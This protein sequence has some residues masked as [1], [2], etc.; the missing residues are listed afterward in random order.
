MSRFAK[1][2]RILGSLCILLNLAAVF[3]PFARRVQEN[4]ADFTWSQWDYIQGML[5]NFLPFVE[6]GELTL[7]AGSAVWVL[8]LLLLPLLLSVA[9]GVWGMAGSYTQKGSSILIFAVLLFYAGMAV[10]SPSVWPEA[11][12]G[13]NIVRGLAGILP[14]GFSGAAAVW[15]VLSLMATPGKVEISEAAIPQVEEI[16]QEQVE[17]KYSIMMEEQKQQP[18]EP[19]HGVLIGLSGMYAGARIPMTDGE[20]LLLGRQADNHLVFE[21]QEN[22]SRSHC[23]IKWD[24]A[25]GKY[26]IRDYSSTG[27]YLNGTEDCLP[28]N[29]DLA[30]APGSRIALGNKDNEFCLK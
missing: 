26:F 16:R 3:L 28:Q 29:L 10:T 19:E 30:L 6:K 21:G 17:A 5:S 14:L 18:Q 23:R 13:Q 8:T 22:V 1:K 15:A 12:K 24:A 11:A 27:T 9:A 25:G 4:Y 2:F 20:Y 7:N